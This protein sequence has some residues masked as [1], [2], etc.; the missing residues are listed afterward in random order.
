MQMT[1]HEFIKVVPTLEAKSWA[2]GAN[3]GAAVDCLGFDEALIVINAGVATGTLDA[4][5]QES[6]TTTS[7]DFTDIT[8]AAFTTITSANDETLYVGRVRCSGRK[9]YLRVLGTVATDVVVFGA[10]LIL[11]NPKNL[12]VSQVK[13]VAFNIG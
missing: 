10:E 9:R 4:K 12:P 13:T 3:A 5:V 1:A 11:L 7:G 8:D 2:V 6:A